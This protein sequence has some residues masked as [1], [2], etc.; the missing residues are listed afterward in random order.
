[1][2]YDLTPMQ[3]NGL[4][5]SGQCQSCTSLQGCPIVRQGLGNITIPGIGEVDWK[6]LLV[7]IV[8]GVIVIRLFAG[9]SGRSE[10]LRQRRL[11]RAKAQY[12][13]AKI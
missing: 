9:R 1:M 7:A 3:Q 8:A 5:C 10:R 2:I 4:G 11:A 6:W 12:E 13:L